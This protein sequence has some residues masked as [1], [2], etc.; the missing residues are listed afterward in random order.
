MS[1]QHLLHMSLYLHD[2]VELGHGDLL[3]P[4]DRHRHLLLVFT[5]QEGQHLPDDGVQPLADLGL[6]VHL[7][8]EAIRHLVV[9][10]G[11]D[12]FLWREIRDLYLVGNL[13]IPRNGLRIN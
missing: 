6:F 7:H 1:F 11:R 8:V 10:K 4:L 12:K 13:G 9:L 5:G 2:G 3:G